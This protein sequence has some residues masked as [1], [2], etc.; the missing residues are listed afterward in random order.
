MNDPGWT[1]GKKCCSTEKKSVKYCRE[2][3]ALRDVDRASS[4][5]IIFAADLRPAR[6]QNRRGQV[7]AWRDLSQQS[8]RAVF[9]RNSSWRSLFGEQFF[10][11]GLALEPNLKKVGVMTRVLLVGYDPETAD[12]SNPA[13]PPDMSAEKVRAGVSLALREMTDRG[14]EGDVCYI[15]PDGMAGLEIMLAL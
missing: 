3:G 4:F 10:K 8:M 2:H 9:R 15:R 5:V 7:F 14:W 11:V 13:L 12:Y 1:S 6:P